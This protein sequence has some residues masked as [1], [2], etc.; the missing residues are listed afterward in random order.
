MAI[1]YNEALNYIQ[2]KIKSTEEIEEVDFLDSYNRV[3][4]EDIFAEE[5]YPKFNNSA[6]DGYAT[7]KNFITEGK[8]LK[9]IG[10]VSAGQ[11]FAYEIN[12][13]ECYKVTTGTKLPDY[14]DCVVKVE[15]TENLEDNKIKI[16]KIESKSN[17][18]KKG[19]DIKRGNLLMKKGLLI[20]AQHIAS[21]A[22]IGKT[23]VKVFKKPKICIAST[24][25]EIIEPNFPL[26][27]EG[28]VR[29]SNAYQL[30]INLKKMGIEP[31]YVGIIKDEQE[32]ILE[33]INELEKN[34][35]IIIFSG[36]VSKGDHDYVHQ[37]VKKLDYDIL[38]HYVL[39]QPGFPTLLARKD[40]TIF[41]GLPG[42][43]VSVFVQFEFLVKHSI[44]KFMGHNYEPILL[45]LPL[46]ND[47]EKKTTD[48]ISLI[49]AKIENN[50]VKVM[51]F[52]GSGHIFSLIEANAII[53]LP[54]NTKFF[55]KG[56]YVSVRLIQ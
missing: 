4:A 23:R 13:D 2:T 17:I 47:Y 22:S 10:F 40:S 25:N 42:N 56:T 53:I 28:L 50:E 36:G 5:D 20:K 31:Y 33:K 19:E 46:L 52:H 7:L 43:P 54:P 34:F 9:V 49:P 16:L 48:R 39:I 37:S 41:W 45:N 29:N 44:Y 30:M 26:T 55:K 11:D 24:G 15:N 51:K 35:D 14:I 6:V 18:R 32:K 3:L 38:F 27:I 1:T 8:I 21:L 12:E